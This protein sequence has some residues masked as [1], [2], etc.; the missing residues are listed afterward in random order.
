MRNLERL[1]LFDSFAAARDHAEN[2][3]LR[4]LTPGREERNGETWLT[5][6]EGHGY[7]ITGQP[8]AT[9]RRG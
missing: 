7:P 9:A 8:L 4:L 2:T 6:P 5:I 1:A 3:P